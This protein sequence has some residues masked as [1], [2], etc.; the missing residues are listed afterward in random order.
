MIRTTKSSPDR[1]DRTLA[2]DYSDWTSE[3]FVAR[4]ENLQRRIDE[5][6]LE[7]TS[8]DKDD[9]L[10]AGHEIRFR[11][12]FKNSPLPIFVWRREGD[13]FVRIDHNDAGRDLVHGTADSATG[14][15]ASEYLADW[16]DLIRC[17]H[18]CFEQRKT[19]THFRKL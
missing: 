8:P 3:E 1:S 16:P 11:T 9:E 5:L 17:I 2:T 18:H 19:M 12:L 15:K 6:E 14:M 4:L 13:D 10:F 7:L